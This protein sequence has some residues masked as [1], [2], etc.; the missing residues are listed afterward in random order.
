[1]AYGIW[2]FELTCKPIDVVLQIFHSEEMVLGFVVFQL[3]TV[4]WSA[5]LAI[6]E[7]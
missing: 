2:H 6:I 4:F 1:V 7:M 3:F 5:G